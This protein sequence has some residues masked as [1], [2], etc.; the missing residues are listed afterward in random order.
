MALATSGLS[1]A[2]SPGPQ[3]FGTQRKPGAFMTS[4]LPVAGFM[5]IEADDLDHA[6]AIVSDT[7]CAVPHGGVEVWPLK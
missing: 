3:S 2:A 7:P 6:V 4:G 1:R 5:V